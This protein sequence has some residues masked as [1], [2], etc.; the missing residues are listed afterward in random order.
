[1]SKQDQPSTRTGGLSKRDRWFARILLASTPLMA[2]EP[3]VNLYLIAT[4]P[5]LSLPLY[6]LGIVS[7]SVI[8]LSYGLAAFCFCGAL[9][10]IDL[11]KKPTG[12]IF[13]CLIPPAGSEHRAYELDEAYDR[14]EQKCGNRNIAWAL[15]TFHSATSISLYWL[16]RLRSKKLDRF[17]CD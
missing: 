8:L 7:L 16:D 5:E 10:I 13:D 4:N 14:W 12:W 2:V 9:G 3:A 17:E 6:S 11:S 15:Y 1:M